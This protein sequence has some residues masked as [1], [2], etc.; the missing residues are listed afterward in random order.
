MARATVCVAFGEPQHLPDVIDRDIASFLSRAKAE[1][2]EPEVIFVGGGSIGNLRNTQQLQSLSDALD[3]LG[4]VQAVQT[5]L[6]ASF[7]DLSML[8]FYPSIGLGELCRTK[9]AML[10][11]LVDVLRRV[12]AIQG[13]ENVPSVAYQ[14]HIRDCDATASYFFAMVRRE[15]DVNLKPLFTLAMF[16]KAVSMAWKTAGIPVARVRSILESVPNAEP[17]GLM[18]TLPIDGES[19]SI[20]SFLGCHM[21]DEEKCPGELRD[22]QVAEAAALALERIFV[23]AERVHAVLKRSKLATLVH[24]QAPLVD[25]GPRD[26]FLK[27][28]YARKIEAIKATSAGL[29]LITSV[30]KAWIENI[31]DD[32]GNVLFAL[33]KQSGGDEA[34]AFKAVA[35]GTAPKLAALTSIS[36]PLFTIDSAQL[37]ASMADVLLAN[38]KFSIIAHSNTNAAH[39]VNQLQIKECAIDVNSCAIHVGKSASAMP[40]VVSIFPQTATP[41][42]RQTGVATF[43][44]DV[45]TFHNK[46]QQ[47]AKT[48]D[49]PVS[50]IGCLTGT[51]TGA[52]SFDGSQKRAVIWK[53]RGGQEGMVSVH[54]A[55]VLALKFLDYES[56]SLD[57]SSVGM[58]KVDEEF[59]IKSTTRLQLSSL[60][61]ASGVFLLN[62]AGVV[63][64]ELDL[65]ETPG[66]RLSGLQV[67]WGRNGNAWVLVS[68]NALNERLVV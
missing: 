33:E 1:E 65:E 61:P 41:A 37:S 50:P 40:S 60:D 21:K 68:D 25:A 17:L 30:S 54:D 19:P 14:F 28:L 48:L 62:Q 5:T 4:R 53:K 27:I 12:Q 49:R 9:D 55:E 13:I 20:L 34:R 58:N 24:A 11:E 46:L 8:R 36:S 52:F 57:G 29:E 51:V 45:V 44:G 38:R 6:V 32:L 23:H 43:E 7:T 64:V 22:P 59:D 3:R 10:E 67:Q 16:A 47:A 42:P 35:R 63:T 56:G 2:L 26:A 39:V 31:N 66:D 18:A 15:H